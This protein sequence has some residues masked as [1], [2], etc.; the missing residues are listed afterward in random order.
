MTTRT[1]GPDGGSHARHDRFLIAARAA[2][3]LDGRDLARADAILSTCD[4][5]RVLLA[6]L[7]FIAT[8]TRLLPPPARPADLDFRLSRERAADLARGGL[9]RRLLRPFGPAGNPIVR[10]LA[11]ACT[12]LGL[13]GL[14]V[15]A[16]P[17]LPSP[18]GAAVLP[19][20]GGAIEAPSLQAATQD[21]EAAPPGG[22]VLPDRDALAP[23]G[24]V[25]PDRGALTPDGAS[26]PVQPGAKGT[27]A[28]GPGGPDVP[29]TGDAWLPSSGDDRLRAFGEP[30]P[31]GGPPP[32]GGGPPPLVL[33]SVAFL[34]TGIGLA[35]LRRA[36]L[37]LR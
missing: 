13:A 21:P 6:D 36:A 17:L 31:S 33:L 7:R 34:G 32:G 18:G 1:P 8:A 16:L 27:E 22:A 15:A 11:V 14:L 35:L 24:A 9:R 25:L 10:P 26:V 29:A 5:C 12:T 20:T 4:P 23:G 3:D 19:A 2:G 30:S 37:R 28:A